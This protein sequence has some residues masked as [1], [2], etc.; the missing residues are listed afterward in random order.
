MKSYQQLFAELKRR[1]VFKVSAVYGALAFGLLQVAD[2]LAD[3]LGLPGWFVPLVVA[4]LLVGF[5]VALVLA[6]AFEVTPEG[7]RRTSQAP[8]EELARIV[9]QPAFRRWPAGILALAGVALLVA[10]AWW[11]GLRAGRSDV[12]GDAAAEEGRSARG[13]LAPGRADARPSIAVLAFADMSPGRD[14]EYFSDGITEEILNTLARIRELRVAARTSAFAFK[15][16]QIDLRQVADSLGVDYVVEGS[17]RKD[18]DRL[19]ITAQLIDA[20]DGSHLWSEQYDR[21][22]EDVFAIQTDLAE[23]IASELRV[24]LGLDRGDRLVS[25]TEDLEAFDLYL[26]G[27]RRMRERGRSL[28]EAIALFESALARDSLWAPAWAGLAESRALLP[29]YAVPLADSALWDNSLSAAERAATRALELDPHNASAAVALGNV[30]RDR[31]DW[32]AA[33]AAYARALALDPDNEEA[34]QQY[35]EYLAYVGRLGD[36][37]EAAL[38][39]LELDRS[40]VR[41]DVAGYLALFRG[42]YAAAKELLDQGL[43]LGPA[44]NTPWLWKHRAVAEMATDASPLGREHYVRWLSWAYPALGE[45]VASAWPAPEGRPTRQAAELVTAWRARYGAELWMLR[46]EPE[47]ALNALEADAKDRHPFGETTLWWDVLFDPLRREPR[48]QALRA[49]WG[50]VGLE[51]S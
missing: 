21:E 40:P 25:P 41:Y 32:E 44:D 26:E 6:W 5:P 38:R 27:R 30:H 9:A 34:H 7:V 17:V 4:L 43:S 45:R 28:D 15:G 29:F 46:G 1:S 33:E 42:D 35:A 16:R 13:A 3:A 20:G 31:W 8:R 37:Y 36:A 23:A 2:P 14:Q 10:G 19:R 48:F 11:T 47:R 18:G 51:R 24:P 12:G 22:L 50:L 49:R 39:A